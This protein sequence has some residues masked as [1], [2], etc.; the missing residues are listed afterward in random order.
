MKAALLLFVALT[1]GWSQTGRLTSADLMR[2]RSVGAAQLTP[3]GSRIAYTITNNDK[4]GKPYSHLILETLSG[5]AQVKIENAGAPRWSPDGKWIAYSGAVEG[6]RGLIA[7][8]ADGT[9][10]RFLHALEGTNSPLTFV[11]DTYA[12]SPD[13]KQLVFVHATPGA[14]NRRSVGRS[15]GHHALSLQARLCRGHDPLQ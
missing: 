12:W 7:A 15:R 4:P 9:G 11:G 1:P 6:Q 10:A 14:G 8:K 2:L 5:G 13:S 3:D